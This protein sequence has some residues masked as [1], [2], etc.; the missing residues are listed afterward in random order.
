MNDGDMLNVVFEPVIINAAKRNIKKMN[1]VPLFY[2]AYKAAAETLSFENMYKGLKRAHD[3]SG[4]GIVSNNLTKLWN[5]ENPDLFAA[6]CI[7]RYN[8][9][10]N[11]IAPLH[12]DV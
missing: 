1:I 11:K 10:V 7:T 12:S 3:Y 5:T 8:N 2:D 4:I 9:A 6:A